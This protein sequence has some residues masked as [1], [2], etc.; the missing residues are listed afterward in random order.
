[1]QDKTQYM[2]YKGARPRAL[3]SY[4]S[5][6]PWEFFLSFRRLSCTLV[7]AQNG[8]NLKCV[9]KS[10]LAFGIAVTTPEKAMLDLP[11]S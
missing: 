2:G 4:I 3:G 6:L 11:Q 1:M 10:P 9:F 8:D 7:A 5:V